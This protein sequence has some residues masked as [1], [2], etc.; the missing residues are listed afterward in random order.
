MQFVVIY[1][2]NW[3]NTSIPQVSLKSFKSLIYGITKV[4][5]VQKSEFSS[6]PCQYSLLSWTLHCLFDVCFF[7]SFLLKYIWK[8]RHQQHFCTFPTDCWECGPHIAGYNITTREE[9]PHTG[10]LL[11][12]WAG[13]R[14]RPGGIAFDWSNH[15]PTHGFCLRD[16]QF[17]PSRT[18]S[19]TNLVCMLCSWSGKR[20]RRVKQWVIQADGLVTC[21]PLDR[22]LIIDAVNTG[23]RMIQIFL[24]ISTRWTVCQGAR[25]LDWHPLVSERAALAKCHFYFCHVTLK[26][27]F[28]NLSLLY[29]AH[30][31]H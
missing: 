21:W 23:K 29:F 12:S 15:Q 30:M 10:Y 5:L 18:D 6:G 4:L 9:V 27:Y 16:T 1:G 7:L 26:A 17:F 8:M 31:L 11:E 22:E 13:E 28:A 24:S 14:D 2:C 19:R 20:D 25:H 3:H